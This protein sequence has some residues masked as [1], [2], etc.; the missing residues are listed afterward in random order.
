[1]SASEVE[2]KKEEV[3]DGPCLKMEEAENRMFWVYYPWFML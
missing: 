3:E 1:M 2:V